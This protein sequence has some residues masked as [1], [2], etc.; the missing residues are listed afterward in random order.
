MQMGEIT[1]GRAASGLTMPRWQ[2]KAHEQGEAPGRETRRG[3]GPAEG[4]EGL[5]EQISKLCQRFPSRRAGDWLLPCHRG[6]PARRA[7]SRDC[8]HS[9]S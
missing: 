3:A 1:Q 2:L 7:S 4:G 5:G 8:L 6:I 9:S